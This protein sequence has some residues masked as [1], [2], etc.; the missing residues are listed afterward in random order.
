MKA[1]YEIWDMESGNLLLADSALRVLRSM[2]SFYELNPFALNDFVLLESRGTSLRKV[3]DKKG[4]REMVMKV[5][6]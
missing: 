2:R 6:P 3:A 4:L 5:F 1:T